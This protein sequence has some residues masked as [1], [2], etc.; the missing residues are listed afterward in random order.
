[1]EISISNIY[2][3]KYYSAFGIG[4]IF[5]F[6]PNYTRELITKFKLKSIGKRVCEFNRYTCSH[7]DFQSFI[8]SFKM[9]NEPM[10]FSLKKKENKPY[11]EFSEKTIEF[12]SKINNNGFN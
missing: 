6:T 9:N 4:K 10:F 3:E 12:Q 5:G 2:N 7:Y 11:F 8:S 1:M